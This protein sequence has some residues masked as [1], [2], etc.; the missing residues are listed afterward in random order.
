MQLL[1]RCER[2]KDS[3]P[4]GAGLW[5]GPFDPYRIGMPFSATSGFTT[6]CSF[7]T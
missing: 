7:F 1:F 5:E 4:G 3:Q 6:G 2:E